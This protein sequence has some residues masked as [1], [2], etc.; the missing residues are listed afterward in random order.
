MDA[1][2]FIFAGKAYFRVRNEQTGNE[3]AYKVE[4]KTKY[5]SYIVSVFYEKTGGLNGIGYFNHKKGFQVWKNNDAAQVFSWFVDRLLKNTVPSVISVM[6][7][8]F[9]GRCG[10]RLK[11]DRSVELGF[12]PCCEALVFSDPPYLFTQLN[13]TI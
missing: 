13:I 2:Q 1:I 9:C 7:L 4:W 10:R 5:H 12:G 8:G 6:H 3:F 11:N